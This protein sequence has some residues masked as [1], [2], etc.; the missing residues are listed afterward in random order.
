MIPAD[1]FQESY[2]KIRETSAQLVQ[3]TVTKH[4]KPK[5]A[6]HSK[7]CVLQQKE[8]FKIHATLCMRG[9]ADYDIYKP[10]SAI[11]W[12]SAM[13]CLQELGINMSSHT[14]T[15]EHRTFKD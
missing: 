8:A 10:A 7:K 2:S 12:Q 14:E 6:K 9:K 5:K 15:D 13:L 4:D 3:Y 1:L 11:S